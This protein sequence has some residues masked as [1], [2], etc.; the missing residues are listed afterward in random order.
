MINLT[1]TITSFA[2]KN[3]YPN[4]TSGNGGGH[5]F[6]CRAI[7]NPGRHPE[8]KSLTGKDIE[9]QEFLEKN[10]EIE[11]FLERSKTHC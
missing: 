6:D 8:Y 3:G 9:V 11:I 5:V 4:D 7:N 10:S 1:V 2:Y